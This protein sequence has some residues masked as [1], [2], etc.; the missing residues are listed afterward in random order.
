MGQIEPT[1]AFRGGCDV[2]VCDGFVGNVML[3][4]VEATAEVVSRLLREEILRHTS[5]RLGAWLLRGALTR[6]R[7][8]TDYGEFGGGLLLGVRGVVVIG[9]GRSDSSA[10]FGAVSRASQLASQGIV[11]QLEE[12]MAAAGGGGG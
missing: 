7:K 12:T 9:H 4:T 11:S 2:L 3:K 10:V 8:R 6:F 5:G 1:E